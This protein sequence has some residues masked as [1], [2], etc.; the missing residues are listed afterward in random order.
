M[1]TTDS[2]AQVIQNPPAQV[3]V[4]FNPLRD[5]PGDVSPRALGR[6]TFDRAKV[7]FIN[8][9]PGKVT[10]SLDSSNT[11]LK[12]RFPSNPIQWVRRI[13]NDD[14][15]VDA[16]PDSEL[17]PIDPP[18]GATVTRVDDNTTLVTIKPDLSTK[19][20]K[21]R[22][23]VIVQTMDGRFFGS[24]PTIVTMPPGT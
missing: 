4:R 5:V 6:V 18:P 24:D 22:F 11:A 9:A 2:P 10:F 17:L 20:Q 1:E 7:E 12:V 19:K 15:M 16:V 21:F 13:G 8:R 23:Y 3:T 14:D